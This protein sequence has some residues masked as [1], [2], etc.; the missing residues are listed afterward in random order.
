MKEYNTLFITAK[1]RPQGRLLVLFLAALAALYILLLPVQARAERKIDVTGRGLGYTSILYDNRNGLITS[2]ANAI[3]QSPEGFLWIGSYS[4]L[5]RY[6]GNEFYRYDSSTGIS[7]VV[8]LFVDSKE[9]LWI[10][11]NDS[12]VFMLKGNSFTN[13]E[14]KDGLTSSTIRSIEEDSAGNIL[15]AT[16]KGISYI[17]TEGKLHALDDER[18]NHEYVC[19]LISGKD[20]VIYGVTL[21][22]DFFTIEDLKITRHYESKSLPYG[23]V[24]NTFYPDPENPGCVYLGTQSGSIIHGNLSMGMAGSRIF[25]VEPLQFVRCL[26]LIDKLLW[27]CANNGIGFISDGRY[28]QVNDLPMNNGVEH[29]MSDY[30]GNLWFTSSRQGVMKIVHNRFSDISKIAGLPQMVVN[31]TCMN[32]GLLYLGTDNGLFI[33]DKDYKTVDNSLTKLLEGTR[34]RSVHTAKDGSLWIGTNSDYGMIHCRPGDV[35]R[36]IYNIS[37]GLA[38]NRARTMM[39]MSDGRIAVATKA[40]VNIIKNKRVV[41]QYDDKQGLINLE[42]L[43]LEEGPNGEIYAGSD[44]DGV[45]ILDNGKLISRIGKE[46]GLR[47]EVILRIRRDPVDKGVYW[48]ITSNSISYMKDGK[49]TTIQNFPYS[50]NFDIFFDKFGRIWV[51][52]SN[53]VYV[54]KREDMLANG[55]IDFTL[56]DTKSGLPGAPTANSFDDLEDDGTLYI[57]ASNGV[58][59]VNINDEGA[60]KAKVRLS[61]PFVMADDKYIPVKN[62]QVRIPADCQRL[63]IYPYAFNYALN[64]PHV[65]YKLDGFDKEPITVTQHELRSLTYTNLKGGTYR[66]DLSVLNT[67]TGKSEQSLTVVLLKEKTIYEQ[68]WFWALAMLSLPALVGGALAFYFRRKNLILLRK[69]AEHKQL[70]DEMATVF[71]NCIDMKDSYTRGH[72]NRV[73]KYSTM[74]ARQM[75]KSEDEIDSLYHTALL[76]DIGKIS[77]PDSI[78]NKPGRL[79]DEEFVVMKSHSQRGYDILKDVTIESNLAT[80]AGFHHER[81]DGRGYPKGLTG[82]NIPEIARIIAVADTFDAMYSTRPYRK[83]MELST[84]AEEIK[85]GSGTQFDPEVV[86][87]FMELVEKGAFNDD[88]PE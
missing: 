42:I 38:S 52:S 29:V 73:A 87:A 30:E 37:D 59:S 40:G 54:V 17:D 21:A 10:G 67:M 8:S 1:N 88:V 14:Q 4:G 33:L 72:S 70:I 11:T 27:V 83:R 45:Y 64:N 41:A 55:K 7:S 25:S 58:S 44:G 22:G 24:I 71:A 85:K 20:K 35:H 5:T 12:G 86:K 81:F 26:R 66:F 43:C 80:G 47:S 2:D 65:S 78:L 39:E 19:E 61:V 76:H 34:V 16:T 63:R 13:Y 69:Q 82:M 46:N 48:I 23:V 75:G 9:R 18:I 31:S 74:L 51:L 50:N 56:Y 53:G 57:A 15:I 32:G 62:G 84:V 60:E 6:D 77:I 3:V 28:I 79:T 36:D 49:I 68:V